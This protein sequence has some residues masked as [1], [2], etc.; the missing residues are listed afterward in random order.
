MSYKRS[1]VC[2]LCRTKVIT[3][4]VIGKLRFGISHDSLKKIKTLVKYK[5]K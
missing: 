4:I 2:M 1:G 5:K 3:Y